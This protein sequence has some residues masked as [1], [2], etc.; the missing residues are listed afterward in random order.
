MFAVYRAVHFIDQRQESERRYTL[1]VDSTAAIKRARMDSLGPGRR[2]AIAAMVVC[3][4]VLARTNQVVTQW[5]PAHN[6]VEGNEKAD[7]FAKAAAGR[8]A[9]CCDTDTPDELIDESSLSYRV[10]AAT[11][12]RSQATTDWIARNVRAARRY[13]PP[14]GGSLCRQHLRGARNELTCRFY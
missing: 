3:D 1:F 8:T 6:K 7:A 5:V 13:R 4:R 10:C 14:P 12:A 2:F 9:P 11:E